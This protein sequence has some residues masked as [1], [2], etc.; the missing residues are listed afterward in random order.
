MEIENKTRFFVVESVWRNLFSGGLYVTLQIIILGI[1]LIVFFSMLLLGS[2]EY[3]QPL[4]LLIALLGVI[5]MLNALKKAQKYA[6]SYKKIEDT[7]LELGA[8]EIILHKG[9]QTQHF[10]T[11]KVRHLSIHYYANALENGSSRILWEYQNKVYEY[12]IAIETPNDTALL[13]D[14]IRDFYQNEVGFQEFNKNG[15]PTYLLKLKTFDGNTKKM[16]ELIAQIGK[17]S[18][19]NEK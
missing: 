11:Q 18:N 2:P 14:C 8:E 13:L 7:F 12:E 6:L 3:A 4:P 15:I 16:E 17:E 19:Q 10:P 5:G 1:F 9:T